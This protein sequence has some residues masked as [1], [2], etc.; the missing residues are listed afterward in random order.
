MGMYVRGQD[1]TVGLEIQ[2]S[3]FDVLRQRQGPKLAWI[4]TC[5]AEVVLSYTGRQ[6]YDQRRDSGSLPYMI[7]APWVNTAGHTMVRVTSVM[8]R[9]KNH[10]LQVFSVLYNHDFLPREDRLF[11]SSRNPGRLT[12]ADIFWFSEWRVLARLLGLDIP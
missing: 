2:A 5:V 6:K 7:I 1:R 8:A 3:G 12:D 10:T 9:K 4:C 11:Q